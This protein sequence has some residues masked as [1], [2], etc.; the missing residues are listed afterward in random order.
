MTARKFFRLTPFGRLNIKLDHVHKHDSETFYG[1]FEPLA[2]RKGKVI[3]LVRDPR[4]I[5]VSFYFFERFY[6][7]NYQ[8]EVSG[9]HDFIHDS[10]YNIKNI[11]KY[12]NELL[13]YVK[14]PII[15]RYED[16]RNNPEVEL[17]KIMT[18]LGHKVDQK[19]IKMAVAKT[20]FKTMK[21]ESETSDHKMLK[22][23]DPNNPES[24]R[25]RRGK[26]GGYVDY[27]TPAD[28]EFVTQVATKL[29]PR[30]GYKIN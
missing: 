3:I 4:D 21:K 25:I 8:D 19:R 12:Y 16:L 24:G 11:I 2:G 5:I 22:L 23:A 6:T 9:I 1:C 17:T 7:K 10:R 27:L 26:I 28:Q 14:N 20:E 30:Y 18:T 15:L 13:V 29:D